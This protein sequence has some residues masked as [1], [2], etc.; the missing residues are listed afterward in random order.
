QFFCGGRAAVVFFYTRCDN[1]NKCSL[2]VSRLAE[3]QRALGRE[4]LRGRVRTAGVTY[5][6]GYDLP[7]RLRAY[8]D[9]RGVAFGDHDRL[10]RTTTGFEPLREYFE[11]GVSF[12]RAVVNRHRIELYL[13]DGHGRVAVT[14]GG[15]R[16]GPE[17][18]PRAG[19]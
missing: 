11:L 10:L 12:A 6:P 3:L 18:G 15:P 13:L 17:G 4:G 7:P 1:P 14:F 16:R 9:N 2:S 8:G 19:A 5:D